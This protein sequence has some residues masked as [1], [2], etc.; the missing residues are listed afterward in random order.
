MGLQLSV[1]FTKLDNIRESWTTRG[2]PKACLREMLKAWLQM[3][4]PHAGELSA[5]VSALGKDSVGK[6]QLAAELEE[7]ICT[8]C[9]LKENHEGSQP[10]ECTDLCEYF[11]PFCT[12]LIFN[13]GS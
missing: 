2:E 8:P 11:F 12:L 4:S 7:T 1:P 5:L 9:A 3:A 10:Q 13:P 6:S